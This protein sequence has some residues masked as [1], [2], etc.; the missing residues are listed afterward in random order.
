ME[1]ILTVTEVAKLLRITKQSVRN[2]AIAGELPAKKIPG[3]NKW[4]F[5][6]EEIKKFLP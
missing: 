6:E 5:N 3:G 4:M 1:K 2:K